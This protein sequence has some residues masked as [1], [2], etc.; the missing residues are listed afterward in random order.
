MPNVEAHRRAGWSEQQTRDL[1]S[2]VRQAVLGTAGARP[3]RIR[4]LVREVPQIR[5]GTGN[6]T[7]AETK[8]G[9]SKEQS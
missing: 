1:I 2:V 9:R 3:E 8:A 6:Q 4:V 7:I 5:W